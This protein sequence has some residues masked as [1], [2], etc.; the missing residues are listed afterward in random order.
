V[1]AVKFSKSSSFLGFSVVEKKKDAPVTLQLRYIC[2]SST[3]PGHA[4][5][6]TW[7]A[8]PSTFGLR[9]TRLLA[10]TAEETVHSSRAIL[11]GI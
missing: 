5:P 6:A 8:E 3:D 10:V 7:V 4:Q 11:T 9:R 2:L 1:T